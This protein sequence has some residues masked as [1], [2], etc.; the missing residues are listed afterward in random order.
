MFTALIVVYCWAG[1]MKKL[2]RKVRSTKK[3]NTY[4]KSQ[5]LSRKTGSIH[6][7]AVLKSLKF[8]K[9][10]SFIVVNVSMHSNAVVVHKSLS[11][12]LLIVPVASITSVEKVYSTVDFL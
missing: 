12:E 11:I 2:M 5:I 6:G 8:P 9:V 4:L 10:W 3:E 1:N 7:F